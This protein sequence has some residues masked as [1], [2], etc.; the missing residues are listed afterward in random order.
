L[1]LGVELSRHH[2]D[3]DSVTPAEE[4]SKTVI[5]LQGYKLQAVE[6]EKE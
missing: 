2:G 6:T 4:Y 5:M 3:V 1:N